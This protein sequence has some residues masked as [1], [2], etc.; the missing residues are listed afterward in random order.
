MVI[1]ENKTIN[2]FELKITRE[3]IGIQ[4]EVYRKPSQTDIII[5]ITPTT[6]PEQHKLASINT[7]IERLLQIPM[8]NEAYQR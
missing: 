1:E 4:D 6:P 2:F 8:K 5:G 3:E 7:Q